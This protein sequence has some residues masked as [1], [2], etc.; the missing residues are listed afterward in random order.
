MLASAPRL[1]L[2]SALGLMIAACTPASTAL[3]SSAEPSASGISAEAASLNA[4]GCSPIRL[5]A[6]D[7]SNVDLTGTW[8]HPA[9]VAWDIRQ[10][11]DCL[12]MVAFD[13]E[14]TPESESV[15]HWTCDG[16]LRV[17]F[18]APGRC[19]QLGR[20]YGFLSFEPMRL[21]VEFDDAGATHLLLVLGPCLHDATSAGC[22]E[23]PQL[24]LT[25]PGTSPP[26]S[27][28]P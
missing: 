16:K 26:G 1:V 18:T 2:G 25:G 23:T 13:S 12:F 19:V 10:L 20:N 7:G 5:R 4:I 6:P 27:P 15:F 22:D 8:S 11:G 3:D 21:D 14:G 9:A 28:S 24:S 17:D